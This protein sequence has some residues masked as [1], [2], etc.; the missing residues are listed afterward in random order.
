MHQIPEIHR[1][2]STTTCTTRLYSVR[3]WGIHARY[4]QGLACQKDGTTEHLDRSGAG[5]FLLWDR[6]RPKENQC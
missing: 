6:L 3:I 2:K 5:Q 4:F 1:E